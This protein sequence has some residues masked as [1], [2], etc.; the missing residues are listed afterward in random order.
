[1]SEQ[2]PEMEIVHLLRKVTVEFGL[3]Q[4]EFA[5]RHGMHPTDVRA[6]ICLL[7]AE[8]AGTD[9]TAGWLGA[10]LGLNSAGTTAVIDRLERLGHLTRTRDPRD[11][12]RVLMTVDPRAVEL[13]RS[14][15]G[16]L[17]DN[18]VAVLRD[19]DESETA[20]VRRFLSAAHRAVTSIP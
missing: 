2:S 8:R 20:A 11:R 12:R 15:F 5:S 14:F 19:F 9:A 3:R 13:G 1:M 4:A 6:L 18:T 17:I 16:P 10:Q 7:D